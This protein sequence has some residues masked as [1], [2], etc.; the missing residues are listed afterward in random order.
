MVVSA[1]GAVVV[2]AGT[3]GLVLGL[4]SSD[5]TE[6]SPTA[7]S[8]APVPGASA[9]Q[10]EPS[11]TADADSWAAVLS[12]A[13]DGISLFDAPDGAATATLGAWT[14]YGTA[15]TL[16]ATAA[17][18]DGEWFEVVVPFEPGEARA[19]VRASD[20]TPHES[21]VSIR[22]FLAERE[23]EVREGDDVIATYPVAVG[24]PDTP[25]P[26]GLTWVT[27]SLA[28][29]NADGVYGVGALGLAAYSDVL[30][31]FQ[32]APP[33][34]AIHGTNQPEL[35]GQ[36]VSNGCI[37]ITNEAWLDLSALAPAG[38]PVIVVASREP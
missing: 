3:V 6:A 9:A 31:S 4:G 18:E 28:Y 7:P 17:S 24:A 19:W 20:V 23:L 35:I 26:L 29:P 32:G 5:A 15:L 2:A 38:T 12:L 1:I 37:R 10:A 27:D 22:V 14:P 11:E 8:D 30:E 16:L 33:Q 25:T 21:G 34:I 13:D 36:A